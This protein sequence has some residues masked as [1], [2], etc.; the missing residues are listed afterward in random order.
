MP[1]LL[2]KQTLTGKVLNQWTIKEYE[3]HTRGKWWFLVMFILGLGLI[4]YGL[5]TQNF[6]FSLIIILFGIILYLQSHQDPVE[7]EFALTELGVAL[8]GKFYPYKELDEFYI[9]YN[10]PHIK[11]LYIET[12][13]IIRPR[14]RIPIGDQD[15]VDLRYTMQEYLDENL[16][17]EEEP[18]SD[19]FARNW[20]LH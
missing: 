17:K 7:V 20:K 13:S 3:K 5:V 12:K 9:I 10:P 2:T 18:L 19:T 14:L 15:P 4:V 16:E 8:G 11:S 1:V 6:I